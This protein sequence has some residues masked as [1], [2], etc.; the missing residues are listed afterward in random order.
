[1]KN[2]I[3][4]ELKKGVKTEKELTKRFNSILVRAF[5]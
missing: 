4:K 2:Y 5:L 3:R 1:M